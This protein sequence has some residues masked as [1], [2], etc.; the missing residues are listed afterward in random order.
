MIVVTG[1]TG[2]LSVARNPVGR[3]GLATIWIGVGQGQAA[4]FERTGGA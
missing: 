3:Y 4:P 1:A 2:V